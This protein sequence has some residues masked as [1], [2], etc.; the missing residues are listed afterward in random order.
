MRAQSEQIQVQNEVVR[1]AQQAGF[2][3]LGD[4]KWEAEDDSA[5]RARFTALN[6]GFRDWAK[7]Y[8]RDD[9][10]NFSASDN[11]EATAE[12]QRDLQGIVS[13]PPDIFLAGL[14]KAI[15][16]RASSY[17]LEALLADFT[18]RQMLMSPFFFFGADDIEDG[19][20]SFQIATAGA[21]TGCDAARALARVYTCIDQG[22]SLT[23][24]FP[25]F[26]G[27]A[28]TYSTPLSSFIY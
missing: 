20:T 27:P 2:D 24:S 22:T 15:E 4:A 10:V 13:G 11:G 9:L 14:D 18:Y 7:A 28:A 3:R 26:P 19:Q 21:T 12:L 5:I 25:T 23:G 16:R 6:Q 8:A 1:T 17:L